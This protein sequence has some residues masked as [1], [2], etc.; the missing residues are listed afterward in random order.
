MGVPS[1]PEQSVPLTSFGVNTEFEIAGKAFR[2]TRSQEF[3]KRDFTLEVVP[4][5]SVEDCANTVQSV[6][7]LRA[8]DPREW[9]YTIVDGKRQV[10]VGET[11][12]PPDFGELSGNASPLN[13]GSDLDRKFL[14]GDRPCEPQ[15][16]EIVFS[17]GLGW[18]GKPCNVK[19][20]VLPKDILNYPKEE[21]CNLVQEFNPRW[22]LGKQGSVLLP[23][24]VK[25]SHLFIQSVVQRPK[26][27]AKHLIMFFANLL[28]RLAFRH[29]LILVL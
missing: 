15:E 17:G 3:R 21:P 23:F 2:V 11:P 16:S 26:N 14:L 8:A 5:D 7:H 1:T 18:I 28:V 19:Y 20:Y 13:E 27:R 12:I 6:L 22:R 24:C 9:R 10:A 29:L 25:P 4:L